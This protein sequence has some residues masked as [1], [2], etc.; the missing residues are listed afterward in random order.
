MNLKAIVR[1][2]AR[3]WLLMAIMAMLELMFFP[4]LVSGNTVIN[5]VLNIAITLASVLFA[6]ANGASAGEA[7]ISYGE[8]L[9]KRE[10]GGYTATAEDRAKCYNRMRA[11]AGMLVGAL[12]WVL[13]ALI[14]LITG[15]GHV[16]VAAEDVPDYLFPA[17]SELVMEPHEIVDMVARIMFSAFVGFFTFVDN[18]GPG[19]LDYLFLPLSFVYPLAVFIGYLSGPVQHRKKLKMI[20]EGKRKKL[21]KIRADQRRKKRQQQPRQP[22]PEV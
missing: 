20:E 18:A 3:S 13:M 8:L 9:A 4:A 21:R 15:V 5:I 11:L 7:E 19:L 1:M 12:P 22:K 2:A 10:A 16:H 14:V 17:A 6:F